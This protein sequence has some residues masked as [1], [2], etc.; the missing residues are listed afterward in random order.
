MTI[1]RRHFVATIGAALAVSA[2]VPSRAKLTGAKLFLV[3]HCHNDFSW[4]STHLWDRARLPLAHKEALEIMRRE[5]TFKWFLDVEFEALTPFLER[6]PEM[7]GELR[8][9]VRE[10]RFGVAAGS[11]C[12]PDNPFMEAESTIR[13]LV[14]GRRHFESKFPGVNLD[15]AVFNDIHPGHSQMPQLLR[16]AGYRFYRFTRP[17]EALDKKGIQ[18]EFMW[19]GLDG[20]EILASYGP[21]GSQFNVAQL[22]A[23]NGC[24]KDWEKA[25]KAFCEAALKE[26]PWNTSSRMLYIP[27]GGDYARPLRILS[28]ALDGEPYLDLPGFVR[29]WEKH[30]SIPLKFATPADYF[31]ELDRMRSSLRHVRGAIDTVGWPFW[32][33]S[34]GSRGLDNWRERNTVALVEA[35]IFSS[36]GGLV[37]SAYPDRQIEALWYDKLTL[38]PHDGLYV[39]DEDMM[40][41][42]EV[43]RHVDYQCNRLITNALKPF[44]YRIAAGSTKQ[45]VALFNPLSWRRRGPVEIHAVFPTSGTKKVVV[46]DPQGHAIPHQVLSVRHMGRNEVSY[47]EIWILVEAE[48]PALGY[49]TLYIEPQQGSEDPVYPAAPIYDSCHRDYLQSVPVANNPVGTGEVVL[50]NRYAGLQLGTTGVLSLRDKVRGVEYPWAGNVVYYSTYDNWTY[51]GGPT[52]QTARIEEARWRMVEDGPL[53]SSAEMAG[54]IGP[55]QIRTR[56]SLFHSVERIQFLTEI[57]SVGGNGYFAA[58]ASFPYSGKL[59][60]GIPFGVEDRDL[61][62]EPF[63]PDAGEERL[64]ENTFYAHHWVDYSDGQKGLTFVAAEGKRGFRFDPK[65]SCLD[66]ILLMTIIPRLPAAKDSGPRTRGEAETY[67][68]NRHFTGAG[69]HTFCYSLI[70]HAGN[71]QN[72]QSVLR[73]H[74][75]LYPVR[76][77]HLSPRSDADLPL[78]KSF[79][80]ITPETVA[81]STWFR[82]Q[83]SHFLRVYE[84]EGKGGPVRVTV[85]FQTQLSEAVDFNGRRLESPQVTRNGDSVQFQI[86]PWQI[87][88]LRLVPVTK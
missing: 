88:T 29:D 13:N 17:L 74:E 84:S 81:I 87:V 21:Y 36:L 35:E 40:D 77:L 6:Y 4:L 9:R 69:M 85:P 86:A 76:P 12:N 25:F 51:H 32:Y 27:I 54:R 42:T 79:L 63:G 39:T 41:L 65:T 68:S 24:L 45:A 82:N 37:G 57:D 60:A 73:A 62:Q 23:I 28:E 34:C 61:S 19:A 31:L 48:V 20:S 44:T 1:H 53:R 8:D 83:E 11:F 26:V 56:I 33:G 55:H 10:G 49:T 52:T 7:F 22:E 64:R 67:F 38:D 47:K 50:E 66:H 72:A 71:W 80:S 2:E 18:R 70:P 14:F 16:Q 5:N 78:Q 46:T 3:P 58:Q 15:V 75:S 43:G 30:E 59:Y